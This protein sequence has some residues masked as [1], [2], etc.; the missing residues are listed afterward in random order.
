MF[1]DKIK[2]R[3]NKKITDINRLIYVRKEGDNMKKI[4]VLLVLVLSMGLILSACGVSPVKSEREALS[5]LLSAISDLK[6]ITSDIDNIKSKTITQKT[7]DDLAKRLK[8]VREAIDSTNLYK[9]IDSIKERYATANSSYD[10]AEIKLNK[11]KDKIEK[12]DT[13]KTTTNKKETD[14]S[15]STKTNTKSK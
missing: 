1:F 4:A 12:E 13:K 8:K 15:T 7:Y 5:T 2:D 10:K 9:D 14:K 6:S 3:K 11:L